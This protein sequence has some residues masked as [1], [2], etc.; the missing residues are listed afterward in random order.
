[1]PRNIA[2]P[3]IDM[4]YPY[5]KSA[6]IPI[7]AITGTNGKTTTTRLIAHLVKNNGYRVGFTTSDGIYVQNT[8]MLKGDT[9]GP[10]S[11]E[12]I[13]KDPTVEFAVLETARGGILRSGLGFGQCD[14]G[15][16]TN[17]QEDHLGLNDIH[18]LDELSRVKEVV[19][20]SVKKSGWAVINADNEYCVKIGKRAGCHVVYFSMDENNPIIVQQSNLGNI[21]CVYENG[22]I[23][24]KKGGWK[25]RVQK[26]AQI[27]L[28]F[29]GTVSFMIQNVLA[30]TLT[31]F[32]WGFRTEDIK[33][34][35]ETFIPSAAQTPGRMNIF[36]FKDF[37][38]MVDFAHNPDG[39]NGIKQFLQT[40]DSPQKI[41]LIAATGDRRD[42][43]IR[44]IG[45]IAAE[46]FDHIILRQENHLRGRKKEELLKLMEEGVLSAEKKPTYEIAPGE[47]DVFEHAIRMA[48]P[49]AFIVAL[50]DVVDNAIDV[51]LR[52]QEKE[53]AGT[54]I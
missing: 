40:I 19:I 10:V 35:L 24:I 4:L 43:D 47:M 54:F 32:V 12:F 16:L 29:G 46:M 1:M 52:F 15:V 44:E 2:A 51:V 39:F 13:L 33:T 21:S 45:R 50:S 42:E 9:T 37:K 41:G 30:A 49:S 18:T 31:A 14:I 34:S 25:I 28:T 17:I 7:I 3:V 11:A 26:A 20:N 53:R 36:P 48:K 6:R 8:L 38:I 22:Y 5:G 23:T 27:P